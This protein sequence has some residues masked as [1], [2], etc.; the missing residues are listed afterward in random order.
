MGYG[1]FL[2][3]AKQKQ[4]LAD[5]LA[6]VGYN[7]GDAGMQVEEHDLA[8]GRFGMMVGTDC[9]FYYECTT[10]GLGKCPACGSG[11]V[12]DE[13]AVTMECGRCAG[14]KAGGNA[15]AIARRFC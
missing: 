11:G 13:D 8:D 14:E 2:V 3:I 7:V 9:G 12:F 10:C 6:E 5:F 1:E 15:G 4:R